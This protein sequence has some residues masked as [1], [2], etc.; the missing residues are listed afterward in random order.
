MK[1]VHPR[2]HLFLSRFMNFIG[3]I[4]IYFNVKMIRVS[5]SLSYI[6]FCD[7]FFLLVRIN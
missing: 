4:F 3:Y 5:V 6:K 7:S 2:P 1:M